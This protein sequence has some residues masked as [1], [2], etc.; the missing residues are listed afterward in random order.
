MTY[1]NAD[2]FLEHYGV[3]GQKWGV[4]R[5]RPSGSPSEDARRAAGLKK[6]SVSELNNKELQDL[7]SRMNLEQQYSR[8]NP[9][10]SSK[11][12]KFVKEVLAL[13]VTMNAVIAFAKSPAGKAT[14][15]AFSKA[16]LK[17]PVV[18]RAVNRE[19]ALAALKVL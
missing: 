12:Q 8:L 16:A 7:V 4:R 17:N 2:D 19:A 1:E 13:G 6:K 15:K 3:K 14:S 5:K 10:K 18:R 9:K 11:G